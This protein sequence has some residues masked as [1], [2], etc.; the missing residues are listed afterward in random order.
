LSVGLKKEKQ[1]PKLLSWHTLHQPN[2]FNTYSYTI[3]NTRKQLI[4]LVQLWCS[5]SKTFAF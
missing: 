2:Q 1:T 4:F 3:L 5:L